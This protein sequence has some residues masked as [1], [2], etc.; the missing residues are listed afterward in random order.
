ML[1]T[2]LLYYYGKI[3]KLLL[4]PRLSMKVKLNY[5]VYIK[6]NKHYLSQITCGL[7]SCVQSS[8]RK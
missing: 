1:M 8:F 7:D 4:I 6:P 2:M 3:D 5:N